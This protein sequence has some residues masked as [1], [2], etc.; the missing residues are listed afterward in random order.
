MGVSEKPCRAGLDSSAA[1]ME[2]I[3]QAQTNS[4]T[5]SPSFF[6]VEVVVVGGGGCGV[7][8]VGLPGCLLAAFFVVV[9]LGA[10]CVEEEEEKQQLEQW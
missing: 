6:V 5:D 1:P 10:A 7:V 2:Y 3:P 4:S 8:G 9:G